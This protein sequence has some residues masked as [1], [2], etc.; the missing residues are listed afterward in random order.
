MSELTRDDIRAAVASGFITEAQAASIVTLS[1]ER[2]GVRDRMSGLDEPFEL[3]R[4][5]NEIF[6]V[7]GLVILFSGWA[8]L[9]G[10]SFIG[11]SQGY[12]LA[13]LFG[14]M[15]AGAMVALAAYFTMKRRMVAPSIAIAIMFALSV[16][17]FGL[18]VAWAFD[19]EAPQELTITALIT[20][21]ALAVYFIRFRV[22]FVV[23]LISIGVFA[24]CFGLVFIGGRFPDNIEDL[25]LLSADGPFAI[26]TFVLGIIGFC[27]AMWF[28]MGD[29]HR[30]MLRS[31]AGFW[32]H[33]I[34][35]PA[36]INTVA[37]TLFSVGTI[38]AQTVLVVFVAALAI[39]AVVIDRRSF[40]VSG[41]GYI[42][43]VAVTLL[44]DQVFVAI[45]AL[46]L[47]LVLL[48]AK[49]E[50]LRGWMMTRLPDFPGKTRLP[51]WSVSSAEPRQVEH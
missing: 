26:L 42:V 16:S 4:G 39:V 35:A 10:L 22:P 21:L 37:L 6:I 23:A 9:T 5:F 3:F 25:F 15:G 33:I 30:V 44:E 29:P 7:V 12:L 17:Q 11:S 38:L 18:G 27:I 20:T 36:I 51:P 32:L 45:L 1:D 19:A 41:V 28:D 48:G 31:R 13:M 24:T 14:C 49:W 46:G 43:A 47:G 40:L 34:A 2:R 8:G 50:N